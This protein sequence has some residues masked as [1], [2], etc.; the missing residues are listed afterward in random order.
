MWR[1]HSSACL[2]V[3]T[4][5][6]LLGCSGG[7]QPAAN[8]SA[9]AGNQPWVVLSDFQVK[10]EGIKSTVTVNYRFAEGAPAPG[11]KYHW[12]IEEQKGVSNFVSFIDE[13]VE[14]NASGGTLT[15]EARIGIGPGT[16]ATVIAVGPRST[17]GGVP[18]PE[19]ISGMLYE[20]QRESSVERQTPEQE[21]T[22]TQFGQSVVLSQARREEGPGV[23]GE[24]IAVDYKADKLPEA[25]RFFMNLIGAEGGS[26]SL[27]VTDTLRSA[28]ST[29]T[30]RTSSPES[31][32]IVAPFDINLVA[33]PFGSGNG[34]PSNTSAI[35]N[36]VQLQ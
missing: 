21:A 2:A 8:A 31:P 13:P 3:L 5:V 17:S 24:M 34:P 23:E 28:P 33:E 29:G 15:T 6:C 7:S 22:P 30:L 11:T 9:A 26:F 20:G 10:R 19:H 32:D 1:S 35:S 36:T 25:G 12:I 18:E 4:T 16:M 27:E 14:L